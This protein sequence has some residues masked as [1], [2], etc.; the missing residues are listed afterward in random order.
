MV[1]DAAA[2]YL[3]LRARDARFD[4][5]LFVGVTTTGVY[6]RPVCRVRTPRPEH[7]RFF[8]SAAQAEAAAFRPCLKCRPE[9]APGLSAMD[10]SRVLAE[11]A[12][13]AIEHAVHAGEAL[14]LARLASRLG[15]TDRHL[16]RIFAA[17][18]GVSPHAYLTTQRLLL[19]KQLLTDTAQPVTRVAL[20]SGFASLR[21][22]NAAFRQRYRLAPTQLRRA[23]AA[24]PGD[25]VLR[26]AWRPPYD[27]DALLGFFARRQ[28]DGV[29]EVDPA[30]LALRR[31]LALVHG[32][33]VHAGWLEVRFVPARHE[34]HV[35]VCDALAPAL[36]ELRRRARQALDLDADPSLIDPVLAR[37]PL[38]PRPGL[39][40]PGA[41]DGFEVAVRT[42][43]GQQVS[44]K[45]ARTLANRLVER[46]GPRL[47]TPHP[48][49]RRL[50]PSPQAIAQARPEEIGTLG[51]VR[52][53]V[54]A[55][56]ALA[57]E[58]AAGR[59]ALHPGAPLAPTLAALRA[60]PGI[61]DWTA[62]L[63]AMRA[64]AWPDAWPSGDVGLMIALGTRD[65]KRVAALAEAWRPWRAYA[66]LRL[67]HH[68]E[69]TT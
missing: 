13:R 57:R 49:L 41:F 56:Q 12:A 30:T 69:T 50:F 28:L 40:L 67:W 2:A 27:V 38:P 35:Q 58:V 61:G 46:F 64:L 65:A 36:G 48:A 45:A 19:A 63:V 9:V 34:V 8:A 23:G 17:T 54:A 31:T 18:H 37:L 62:Q 21:R 55:L 22:F 26:L 59:L 29:E 33:Q 66:L 5:R 60:L 20:A 7:C 51:I 1:A 39:R 53:R 43:L 14:P 11:Q 24:V 25:A 44:V 4:G 47:A 16:R 68:V 6:C 42:V 3:A 10:S 32:G 15:V 52:Q